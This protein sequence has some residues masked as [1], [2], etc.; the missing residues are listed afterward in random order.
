MTQN[1]EVA[2]PQTSPVSPVSADPPR[3]VKKE[4]L[5]AL[6][7][8][9]G[10]TLFGM[11]LVNSPGDGRYYWAPLRH[12]SWNGWSFAELIFPFF[13]FIVGVAIPYSIESRRARGAGS[14]QIVLG[15]LRRSLVLFA[16]GLAMNWYKKFDFSQP[17]DPWHDLEHLRFFNVLQRIALCS[18]LATLLYLWCKPKAQA[19]ICASI[20]VAYYVLMMFVPAP[21]HEAG[22]LEKIGNWAQYIDSRVMGAHCGFEHQGAVFEAKGLLS[23]LPALVTTLLGVA[24]GCYLRSSAGA[25]ERIVNLYF[26]GTLGMFLG[27]VWDHF[28]PINQILWTSSLVLFMGGMAMVVLASCYY[29]ADVRKITW[30]TPPLVVFGMNSIAVWV[31]SVVLQDTMMKIKVAGSDGVP[32]ALKTHL[33]NSLSGWLGPWNGSMAFA[34]GYVLFWL[35][36]LSVLY[37][38]GIVFKV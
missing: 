33:V 21:G 24:T 6:D 22:T 19:A 14:R 13:L 17:F 27:A 9:R 7:V 29:V 15:T 37:R 35:V 18:F 1:H 36:V 31:G 5:V 20:L 11:V 10:L 16:I 25:M 32:I 2:D 34:F 4:R 30:W 26:F 3:P 28:F 38:K 8:F 12:V 23:T